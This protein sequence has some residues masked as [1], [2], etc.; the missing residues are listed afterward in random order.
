VE[1]AVGVIEALG[2]SNIGLQLDQYHAS[3]AGE[4]PV[5][6]LRE[7]FGLIAHVQIAD[8]PGRHEPGTGSAPIQRFLD[9]LDEGAFAGFVGLEYRPAG[10]TDEGLDWIKAFGS[11]ASA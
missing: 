2:H 3:M 10:S 4:D 9:E 7:N 5:E 1:K 11:P 8:A 6:A